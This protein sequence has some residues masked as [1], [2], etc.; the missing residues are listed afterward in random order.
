MS[1]FRLIVSILAMEFHENI[2]MSVYGNSKFLHCVLPTK[3]F[4]TQEENDVIPFGHSVGTNPKR[5]LTPG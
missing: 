1:F 2:P 4:E 3:T 5:I